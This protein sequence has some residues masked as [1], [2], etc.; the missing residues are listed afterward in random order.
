MHSVLQNGVGNKK[1]ECKLYQHWPTSIYRA[2][3]FRAKKT[4]VLLG[5]LLSMN[6][7]EEDTARKHFKT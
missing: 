4:P 6:L 7:H 3:N 2:R 5:K 1:A